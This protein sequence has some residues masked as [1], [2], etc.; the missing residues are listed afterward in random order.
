MKTPV[1]ILFAVVLLASC[2]SGADKADAYGNFESTEVTVSSEVAGKILQMPV[3]EGTTVKKGDLLAMVDTTIYDLQ[4][5]ELLAAMAGVRTRINTVNAQNEV[6]K[7]QIANVKVNVDRVSNM[8]KDNAATKKQYD[9]LSGQIAVF[10]RQIEANNTQR[11]SIAA[12]LKVYESKLATVHEQLGRCSVKSPIDGTILDKY[13]EAGELTA[14]GK[15]LVKISDLAIMKLKVYV[16]GAD[17]SRVKIGNKCTIRID[18]SEKGYRTYSATISQ[19][20]DKAEFTPKIIQTKEE[21]VTLVYAVII[22]V[23]NDGNL[24]SGMPGEAIFN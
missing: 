13:A 12:E 17:I 14:Q 18:D 1:L 21:R 7:Q 10:E 23:V 24:K 9:D 15:P 3:S 8:L 5:A 11:S 22:E 16:S 6:L 20:A 19:V 4:R 2:K